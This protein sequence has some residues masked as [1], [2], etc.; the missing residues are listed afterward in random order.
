M[1][2]GSGRN[3][4]SGGGGRGKGGRAGNSH[5]KKKADDIVDDA[6]IISRTNQLQLTPPRNSRSTAATKRTA[7]SVYTTPSRLHLKP[8]VQ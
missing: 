1:P 4:R 3:R 2:R 5:S 7:A 8:A 6:A